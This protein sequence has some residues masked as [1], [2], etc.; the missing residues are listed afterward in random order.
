MLLIS[1]EINPETRNYPE[2]TFGVFDA[3]ERSALR[4]ALIQARKRRESR[5]VG[6]GDLAAVSKSNDSGKRS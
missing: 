1:V 2:V 6:A 4:L 5:D 3:A